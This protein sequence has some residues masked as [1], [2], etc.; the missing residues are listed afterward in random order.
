MLLPF[1]FIF[2]ANEIEDSSAAYK[3]YLCNILNW[4]YY[5]L[6]IIPAV[7]IILDQTP[8]NTLFFVGTVSVFLMFSYITWLNHHKLFN[9]II[10]LIPTMLVIRI[11]F[12]F[13]VLPVRELTEGVNIRKNNIAQ[14]TATLPKGHHVSS[15]HPSS[16]DTGYYGR[17]N[18]TY[19]M[20][21]YM[22]TNLG[23]TY[24]IEHEVIKD[25]LYLLPEY[26]YKNNFFTVL[27]TIQLLNSDRD[28]KFYLAKGK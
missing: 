16:V 26:F 13:W 14:F 5:I 1:V 23:Y 9:P 24:Q 21:W 18:M 4:I 12:N 15:Y 27:D 20:M 8:Q 22:S 11:G 28:H 6:P 17:R 10:L 3:K 2:L 19:D 7:P 25:S